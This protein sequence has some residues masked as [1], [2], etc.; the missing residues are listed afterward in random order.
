MRSWYIT[1]GLL[2]I[3]E[4]VAQLTQQ[5]NTTS[6]ATAPFTSS[7]SAL[8]SA[9]SSPITGD[10]ILQF[11]NPLIGTVNGGHVFPGASLPFGMAKA[12][13]DVNGED[14]GGYASD[15]SNVTGFSHMHDSGTGGS[16][17]LGNFPI[18]PQA[19]CD[20]DQ[21]DGCK[22]AIADRAT[23][24]I[25]GTISAT[26][27]Y[28][29]ITLAS[30][31]RAE[32][33]VSN[34]TALYR[35]TFPSTPVATNSTLSPL[36]LADLTDL[37]QSRI[38]ASISV[39]DTSGQITGTGTFGPSFG[40]GT[41]DLHFC[42][43]FS[44]AEIRDTGIFFNNR[45]GTEPKNVSVV[46]DA[47]N[48]VLPAGAWVRFNAPTSDNQILVRVGVSFISRDQACSNAQK[49]IPNFDF[50]ETHQ[51]AR[52]AW[53]DQLST[54]EVAPEGVSTE[55]QTTFWSALYRA[56]LSPQ[57]YTGEN[58]LWQS[59]EP[60]YDS[61]YCIWDSFRSIHP[62][63]TLADPVSQTLMIRSLID[64]YRHEGKLPDCRMSLCKGYT[65]GGSNA[66]I[67]LA[68]F[69]VKNV[70]TGVD[71]ETAYEAVISDAEEEPINW[72]IEGRGGLTS[73]KSLGYIPAD[74]FD[75]YGVGPF[76]RSISRTVEYA[77]DDF[78]ISEMA[79][80]LNHSGDVQK[81]VQRSLNWVNLYNPSQTSFINATDTGFTGYLQ[82]KFLNGTW[83]VQD[84]V[85]IILVA[86]AIIAVSL[87]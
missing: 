23:P 32:M 1:V 47:V 33:T 36:I 8:P 3:G 79:K 54:I 17:S 41:Y 44:G 58:P 46:A 67:V 56:S 20:N 71:W 39:N 80:G 14:Q 43:D 27:G 9:S 63:I 22:F 45:A 78:C 51:A 18:F 11:V 10:D 87:T 50:E 48:T 15:D 25:N 61:Y 83:G 72:A 69:Y 34:H 21:I 64:I 30:Q 2:P 68:D 53:A 77:Y 62:L 37:P 38:N 35:F 31:I 57:D 6:T 42:A 65:Q 19:G 76:T 26:P 4:T 28:F 75:P 16:P 13:A 82:P 55:L 29:D 74:D 24:R 73:W 7:T 52:Q 84:P 60:Y 59:D 12:V 70:S 85:C 86:N 5:W 49:E 81:Y 66:D 40:I